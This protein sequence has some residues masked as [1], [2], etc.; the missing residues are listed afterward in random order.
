MVRRAIDMDSERRY[1]LAVVI[2]LML[3]AVALIFLVSQCTEKANRNDLQAHLRCIDKQGNWVVGSSN[4]YGRC[5]FEK[6]LNK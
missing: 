3:T 1:N 4:G 6:E 5:S 2:T